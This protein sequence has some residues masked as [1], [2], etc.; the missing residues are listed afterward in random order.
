MA[1]GRPNEYEMPRCVDH[2][3]YQTLPDIHENNRTKEDDILDQGSNAMHALA[4]AGVLETFASTPPQHISGGLPSEGEL[5]TISLKERQAGEDTIMKDTQTDLELKC[6]EV[7]TPLAEDMEMNLSMETNSVLAELYEQQLDAY[8]GSN[9]STYWGMPATGFAVDELSAH[10]G[11]HI[12]DADD[13]ESFT[14]EPLPP[15]PGF[16]AENTDVTHAE[17]AEMLREVDEWNK[18][19]SGPVGPLE[20]DAHADPAPAGFSVQEVNPFTTEVSK[21]DLIRC[22]KSS[23]SAEVDSLDFYSKEYARS[24]RL[25]TVKQRWCHISPSDWFKEV[26]TLLAA[27]D[28]EA[29][30]LNPW[31]AFFEWLA[32][33]YGSMHGATAR[34]RVKIKGLLLKKLEA[35]AKMRMTENKAAVV[36]LLEARGMKLAAGAFLGAKQEVDEDCEKR[37]S[38]LLGTIPE[39]TYDLVRGFSGRWS[40]VD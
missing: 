40:W 19:H 5:A 22:P 39:F 24:F 10:P 9:D 8:H 1:F 32:L 15:V 21:A 13:D 17:L 30:D 14:P 20:E 18:A 3:I 26:N 6:M 37:G 2:A 36:E 31:P 35:M 34:E 27:I 7:S 29:N 4:N 11:G 28:N 25:F 38:L 23:P 16:L 12:R 33:F